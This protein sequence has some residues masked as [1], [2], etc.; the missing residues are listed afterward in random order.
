MGPVIRCVSRFT[1]C[2]R[3]VRVSGV[4]VVSVGN[5]TRMYT[6]GQVFKAQM[7]STGE[8]LALKT[9]NVDPN[10]MD[11]ELE[12][13]SQ[14]SLEAHPNIVQVRSRKMIFCGIC[15]RFS[16]RPVRKCRCTG[17]R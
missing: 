3:Y 9:V 4:R 5:I 16:G 14:L 17:R 6:R 1:V 10:M 2:V 11:R 13:L 7:A 8:T 12:I 15:S